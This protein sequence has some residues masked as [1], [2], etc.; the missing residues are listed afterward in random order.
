V[1][2]IPR[3]DS[4]APNR[5]YFGMNGTAVGGVNSAAADGR[6]AVGK[7]RDNETLAQPFRKP[8]YN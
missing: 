1:I 6:T 3:G 2:E 5:F 7:V 8:R 4:S